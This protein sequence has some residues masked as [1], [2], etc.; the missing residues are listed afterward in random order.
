[1]TTIK[2]TNDNLASDQ[3]T[4][5]IDPAQ[6][7]RQGAIAA[8]IWRHQTKTGEVYHDFTLSR[9]WRNRESGKTGYAKSFRNRDQSELV[10]VI[11]QAVAWIEEQKQVEVTRSK[12]T[13]AE[14]A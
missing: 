4:Q 2:Q 12:Q 7:I 3:E 11:T 6:V 5:T 9:S 10:Q 14:P 1:M 13:D 8:S